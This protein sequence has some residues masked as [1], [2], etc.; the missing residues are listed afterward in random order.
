MVNQHDIFATPGIRLRVIRNALNIK[1]LT[2]AQFMKISDITLRRWEHKDYTLQPAIRK[3]LLYVGINPQ[4]LEYG[5]GDPFEYE[6]PVVREKIMFAL[7]Q[8]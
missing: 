3:R 7:K 4:W 1:Q 8:K 2:F 6:L 5:T